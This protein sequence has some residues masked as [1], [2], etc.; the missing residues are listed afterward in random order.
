MT[1]AEWIF[2]TCALLVLVSMAAFGAWY[3][4]FGRKSKLR[5][6]FSVQSQILKGKFEPYI[7]LYATNVGP[8]AVTLH[9]AVGLIRD[10]S[11]VEAYFNPLHD[12]PTRWDYSLGPFSGGLPATVESGRSFQSCLGTL[13]HEGLREN[14]IVKVGFLDTEGVYH[15]APRGQVETVVRRVRGFKQAA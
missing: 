11:Y 1:A 10:G 7:A 14:D 3:W 5:V 2:A 4:F 8:G 13:D 6:N 9:A 12:F 15:W